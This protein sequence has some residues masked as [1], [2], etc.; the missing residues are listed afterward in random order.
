MTTPKSYKVEVIA[1]DSGEWQ[2]KDMR[3][4]TVEQA[5]IEAADLKERWFAVRETRILE[6]DDPVNYKWSKGCLVEVKAKKVPG[7]L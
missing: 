6:S 7:Q 1:D 3:F 2:G 4:A 5:E